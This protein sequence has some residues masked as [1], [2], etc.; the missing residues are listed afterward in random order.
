[1]F[2][3]AGFIVECPR[4]VKW[5]HLPIKRRHLDSEFADLSVDDLLVSGFD[6]VIKQEGDH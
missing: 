1:M 2:R 6:M 5:D 4:V 3:G